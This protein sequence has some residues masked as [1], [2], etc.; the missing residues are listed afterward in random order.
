MLK[1]FCRLCGS[2]VPANKQKDPKKLRNIGWKNK[3]VKDVKDALLE[4]YNI[5]V[6]EDNKQVH[7]PKIC[8]R[9]KEHISSLSKSMNVSL[10]KVFM[11]K[12]HIEVD[13]HVCTEY[14]DTCIEK[15]ETEDKPKN[16]TGV[17]TKKEQIP[18]I[19]PLQKEK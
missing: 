17:I 3:T 14:E 12:E 13:C 2:S 10:I 9:C 5:D 7:P 15:H 6:D 19:L 1:F 18:S 8:S 4:H 11:F 16:E